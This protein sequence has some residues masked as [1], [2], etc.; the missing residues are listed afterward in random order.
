MGPL[1]FRFSVTWKSMENKNVPTDCGEDRG[2]PI[3]P[4]CS[5]PPYFP[6][7]TPASNEL[8]SM[9]SLHPFKTQ[10]GG[11]ALGPGGG[12]RRT[13]ITYNISFS[14]SVHTLFH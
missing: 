2:N 1:V 12:L 10:T 13:Y 14:L 9:V 3:R 7:G 8:A 11:P 4:A 6:E 5:W